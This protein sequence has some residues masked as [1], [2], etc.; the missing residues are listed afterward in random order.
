M[1]DVVRFLLLCAVSIAA[2][3]V[4]GRSRSRDEL[5]ASF[6]IVALVGALVLMGTR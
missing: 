5:T 6:I 4:L 1:G 3:C 2:A